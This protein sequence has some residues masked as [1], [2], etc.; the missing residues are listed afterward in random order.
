MI[1][2]FSGSAGGES[3]LEGVRVVRD[4]QTSIGKGF[5][6]VLFKTKVPT[7][8]SWQTAELVI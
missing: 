2:L 5:A 1:T 6:F 3:E 4:R 7:H 8:Q